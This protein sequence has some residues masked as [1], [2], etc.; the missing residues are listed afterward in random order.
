MRLVQRHFHL[1]LGELV[2]TGREESD[3]RNKPDEAANGIEHEGAARLPWYLKDAVLVSGLH[4]DEVEILIPL[5]S[6]G[7]WGL[8][9]GDT[10]GL[11]GGTGRGRG[12]GDVLGR[13][14]KG[15]ASR[16]HGNSADKC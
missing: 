12:D 15:R 8:S 13:W 16:R 14:L 1:G 5:G 4:R 9:F 10:V 7:N 3:P 2:G 11:D 6:K